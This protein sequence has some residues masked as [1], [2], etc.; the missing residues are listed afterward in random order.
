MSELLMDKEEWYD[1]VS[2]KCGLYVWLMPRMKAIIMCIKFFTVV[3][4][5]TSSRFV[6]LCIVLFQ[7]NNGQEKHGSQFFLTLAGNLD[8]LDG[9]HSVFGEASFFS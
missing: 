3:N 8:Y 5:C 4:F 6:I 9:T 2:T 1:C 7:V